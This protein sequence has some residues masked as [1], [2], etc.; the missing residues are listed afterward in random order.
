[1]PVVFVVHGLYDSNSNRYVRYVASAL[2]D[3]HFGVVVPDMRWHGCAT[4]FPS[5]LGVKESTD[6]L[7]WAAAIHDGK[8]TAAL[9]G[10]PVGMIGFSLGALDVIDTM[11]LNEATT[12]FDAGAVAVSPPADVKHV[13]GRLDRMRTP[14]GYYFRTTLRVRNRRI[15][16]PFW[17]PQP[18]RAYLDWL[19][20]EHATPFSSSDALVAA[21]EPLSRLA[22]VR[23]PLLILAARN[24]PVLGRIAAEALKTEA[25]HLAYV[26]VIAT[27][28]G[29][30]IG[31]L[32]RDPQW[33][34]NAMTAFF[35]NASQIP[36]R[37]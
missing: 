23:R 7:A 14:I 2:A 19:I 26:H 20:K 10:R 35:S 4:S 27:D 21:T 25:A 17:A 12:L 3:G 30:H 33:F 9:G 11:S 31:V 16:I 36:I 1:M 34:V 32:G 6:L 5:T 13:L 8:L 29:G 22:T 15:G 24:D 28:E 18:F 37:P